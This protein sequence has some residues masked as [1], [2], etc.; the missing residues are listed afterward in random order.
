MLANKIKFEINHKK[1]FKFV[2]VFKGRCYLEVIIDIIFDMNISND[3]TTVV[4][5]DC[6][7]L[8]RDDMPMLKQCYQLMMDRIDADDHTTLNVQTLNEEL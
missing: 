5:L 4:K 2:S 8:F 6:Y 1:I 3:A 7:E